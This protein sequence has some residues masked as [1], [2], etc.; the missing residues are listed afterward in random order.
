MSIVCIDSMAFK[1][2]LGSLETLMKE[3]AATNYA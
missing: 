1:R 2:L 3:R